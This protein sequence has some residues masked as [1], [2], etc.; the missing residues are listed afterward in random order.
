[1]FFLGHVFFV[2]SVPPLEL[3]G[4]EFPPSELVGFIQ[5]PSELVGSIVK[6][7]EIDHLDVAVEDLVIALHI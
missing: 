7:L 2:Q 5:P 4:F 3:A 6:Y 1:M